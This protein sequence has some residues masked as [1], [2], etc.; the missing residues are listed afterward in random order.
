MSDQP[1]ETL[2]D[3]DRSS[4][5]AELEAVTLKLEHVQE[6][7]NTLERFF[8]SDVLLEEQW[9]LQEALQDLAEPD[10]L[11]EQLASDEAQ[12]WNEVAFAF[13]E[14]PTA[15][16]IGTELPDETVQAREALYQIGLQP[17][18]SFD[19]HQDAFYD[20]A[21]GVHVVNSIFQ[22][23]LTDSTANCQALYVSLGTAPDGTGF[24]ADAIPYGA[25]GSLAEASTYRDAVQ[26]Q[27]EVGGAMAALNEVERI[28]TAEI[29]Q[30]LEATDLDVNEAQSAP[31]FATPDLDIA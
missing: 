9:S 2:V 15:A 19:L 20:E 23:D 29:A 25:V 17:G 10:L 24:S 11:P 13:G 1:I 28:V 27:L 7:E 31:A 3:A 16:A 5:Q 6:N 14:A 18:L 4:L 22:R 12:F 8:Q 21:L 26:E 30:D